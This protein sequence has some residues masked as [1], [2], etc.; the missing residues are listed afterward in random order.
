MVLQGLEIVLKW[1]SSSLKMVPNGCNMVSKWFQNGFKIVLKSFWN[2]CKMLFEMV[3]KWFLMFLFTLFYNI[4]P[5]FTWFCQMLP[6]YFFQRNSYHHPYIQTSN[7]GLSWCLS[8]AF[9]T[10]V[11]APNWL[12]RGRNRHLVVGWWWCKDVM[13]STKPTLANGTCLIP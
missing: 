4:I 9:V 2:V 6:C 1:F 13:R 5:F 8:R 10:Q 11:L 12:A 3:L 7:L